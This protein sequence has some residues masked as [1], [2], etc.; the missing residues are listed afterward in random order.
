MVLIGHPN[1]AGQGVNIGYRRL[2]L[3]DLVSRSL[4]T[5]VLLPPN[6]ANTTSL[7]LEAL[8]PH[9]PNCCPSL[10]QCGH[11][12]AFSCPVLTLSLPWGCSNVCEVWVQ[13]QRLHLCSCLCV[14]GQGESRGIGEC[15]PMP[16]HR[17]SFTLCQ[18]GHLLQDKGKGWVKWAH[19]PN[20]PHGPISLRP[21]GSFAE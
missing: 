7:S 9:F 10:R 16:G 3:A 17:N 12:A 11:P 18:R 4:L 15:L 2:V 8:S 14:G 20:L 19:A 6:Q 1:L 21:S 13:R 5:A